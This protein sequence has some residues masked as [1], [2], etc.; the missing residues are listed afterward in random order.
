MKP[1][2]PAV[3]P[4]ISAYVVPPRPRPVSTAPRQSMD[5][6]AAE[7][8]RVSGTWMVA[9]IMTKTPSGRLMRKIARHET[10]WTR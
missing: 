1:E 9:M 8:S 10:A 7:A 4:S 5:V 2:T 3:G 6:P